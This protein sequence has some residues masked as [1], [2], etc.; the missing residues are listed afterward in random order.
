ML[1]VYLLIGFLFGTGTAVFALVNGSGILMALMAYSAAGAVSIL[2]PLMVH[3][4]LDNGE[5][6]PWAD[7]ANQTGRVSA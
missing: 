2:L 3:A 1:I 7:G 4:L 5:K 6:D